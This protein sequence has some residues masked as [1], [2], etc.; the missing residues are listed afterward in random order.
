MDRFKNVCRNHVLHHRCR[1]G[2]RCPRDH[3]QLSQRDI[4][5]LWYA[6]REHYPGEFN[7]GG[8]ASPANSQANGQKNMAICRYLN[9][10]SGCSYG[11]LC[12]W[13]HDSSQKERTRAQKV[14][15]TRDAEQSP[16]NRVAPGA[17][18]YCYDPDSAWYGWPE[19]LWAA[20]R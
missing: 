6:A 12:Q 5:A 3:R 11:D 15:A 9:T 10:K 7:E 20:A 18:A 1:L 14:R 8:G 19:A 13:P 17:H 4:N 2:D 16:A